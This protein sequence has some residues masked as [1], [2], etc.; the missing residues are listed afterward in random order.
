MENTYQDLITDIQSKNPKIS[1]KL[2]GGKK[3]KIKSDFKP[4]GDQPEAIKKLVNGANKEEFNQVLLGVTGSGKTFT[5][6]KVIEATNRPALI[7]APNKTLAAQLYGEMK[8]FFPDNAVEYFVSYYDYY[9]PEAY[10]PRSDTYIEKEASINEQIDRMRHSATRSLLE[11]DDVLIVASVSCIYGLGSVEA[12]S[13]MTLTLQKNY[14]YNREHIIKSLVALQYKRNDQNF[15]RGTFRARGE[16][17]EVFP[18]HLE[19]RAWRLS[20]FGDK[21][22]QI[23]EFDP[24]TGNKVRDLSLVKVYAN[25]HYITPKPTIEQAVINIR[26]ELEITLKKHRAEN[27]LLEA[28]RLEERT[29]FDLEMIEATGS[30]AGIENYSR[31]LSGRK[32]GEPPPTL[33]EYFPDNTLIFVDEC[34]V[35]VPQLNGMYK[36][37]RSRKSTLAEYG[38][39]LPSCMDNRPLKFEEWD[40][41]RT[42]TV[43]VSAT[44]GPWELEQT[45]GKFIDQVIRPT[46]LIDPP[47]E[48]RPA[49]NQVDDLMHE[50]KK[51]IENNHRVLVT[52]LTKKMA[53]DL[54][55]YLH[56]N[57]V[58]VRYLHSDIDTLERIEIMRDLRMGVFDVLVGINL[59]RE[60]LDI[61]ECALVGILDADKEGFLRSET[62]LIQTIG[63]AAR[64][65][66]GKVILY[67]DKETKSI[68]KAMQETDRRRSI[69]L[70]YNKKHKI[71]AKTVKKE[72]SDILESVYEKDYVKISEGSNV[73]GN[74]KKHLKA[75]DKKMKESASNLEFE[76]AAKI[77]DEIRKLQSTELE[78][79]LNPKIRQYDVKN[80]I[81]PKG[82]STL[83]MPGTKVTKKRDKKWKHGR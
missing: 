4:A 75:L 21:L 67:A 9:T 65:I 60:G 18:S 68:K 36:G 27:K 74:L 54:T 48:I 10:V 47:V 13:K 50:C 11:R 37:D 81:Y 73:G 25:S 78:I 40:L 1:G 53:E 30:C 52:T 77:R 33:F 55:E 45:K 62:S 26:K 43:F 59:L 41:M 2:E 51:V 61:P 16:Y 46:G 58:K 56:E 5:M 70:A 83:G 3:F 82:R 19:D 24:L 7:L 44:P 29:K 20:L 32:P 49:K 71:D 35:T 28:Q 64:N 79:T 8:T 34:H 39:R 42:Q 57:G 66:D 22:E 17:L 6:A 23:E 12:Y 15:Y 72:I 76:E 14:D 69:Q 31:F 63:R 38:F 80:K